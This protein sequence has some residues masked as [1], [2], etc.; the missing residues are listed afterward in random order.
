MCKVPACI[1]LLFALL[2]TSPVPL[3]AQSEADRRAISYQTYEEADQAMSAAYNKVIKRLT[4]AERAA[5]IKAQ[6]AW[7]AWRDAEAE[8][9]TI[10]WRETNDYGAFL[11]DSKRALTIDRLAT[12]LKMEAATRPPVKRKP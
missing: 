10:D 1:T 11:A 2:V 5:F 7:I 6:K 9:N 4:G 8:S 3:R 12:F